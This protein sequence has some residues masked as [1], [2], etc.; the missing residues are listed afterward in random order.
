M[1]SWLNS[2][3]VGKLFLHQCLLILN[4]QLLQPPEGNIHLSNTQG[5]SAAHHRGF[6]SYSIKNQV[7][8]VAFC[9]KQLCKNVVSSPQVLV[10]KIKQNKNEVMCC[11]V[12][13]GPVLYKQKIIYHRTTNKTNKW[14]WA[15]PQVVQSVMCSPVLWMSKPGN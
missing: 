8:L 5:P 1:T 3:T 9:N 2:Q 15:I 4:F 12:F 6:I 14:L 11:V 7:T 13:R 10:R